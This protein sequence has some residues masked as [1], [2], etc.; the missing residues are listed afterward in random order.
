VSDNLRLDKVLP[1]RVFLFRHGRLIFE[2]ELLEAEA[3]EAA[4]NFASGVRESADGSLM[5]AIQVANAF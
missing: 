1:G 5:Q 2:Q 3:E 4:A